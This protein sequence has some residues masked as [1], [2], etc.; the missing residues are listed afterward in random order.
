[1]GRRLDV[2]KKV[3]GKYV[4]VKSNVSLVLDDVDA[5][6]KTEGGIHIPGVEKEPW[7]VGTVIGVGSK[8]FGVELGNR[9]LIQKAY[10]FPVTSVDGA[11][12]VVVSDD[13]IDCVLSGK[14]ERADY[15][16]VKDGF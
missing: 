12:I 8:A 13:Q 6:S 7:R 1:M 15:D 11:K 5:F 14:A 10:G 9:V 4:P 2:E 3:A 16:M